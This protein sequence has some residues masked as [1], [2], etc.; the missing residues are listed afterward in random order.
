MGDNRKALG[1]RGEDLAVRYLLKRGYK[2]IEKNYRC[3]L[4]EIDLIARDKGTLVFVEIKARSSARFGFP[5]E[6]V[7]PFKQR[8]LIQVAKAYMAERHLGEAIATRFDVVAVQLTPS[9][10]EIELIKDAFQMG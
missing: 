10:P 3:F 6:A 1:D 9:G 8:K 7:S 5:Q 2:V 4:G